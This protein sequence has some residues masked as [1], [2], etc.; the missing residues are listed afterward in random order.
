ML[1]FTGND[2]QFMAKSDCKLNQ[3]VQVSNKSRNFGYDFV[4]AIAI[5][6]VLAVHS[7]HFLLCG[8]LVGTTFH[9]FAPVLF[10][11]C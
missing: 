8:G 2:G 7:K 9:I 11:F 10:F 6:F 3:E 4:R 1:T 5:T